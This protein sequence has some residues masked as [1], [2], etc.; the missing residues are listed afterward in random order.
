MFIK[1]ISFLTRGRYCRDRMVVGFTTAFAFDVYNPAHCE[2]YSIQHY[3]IKFASN[4]RQVGGFLR[5]LP[6]VYQLLA[7]GRW[8]SPGTPGTPGTTTSKTVHH[9]ATETLLKVVL[10]TKTQTQ[11]SSLLINAHKHTCRYA[12]VSVHTEGTKITDM[13]IVTAPLT[14]HMMI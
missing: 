13:C 10:N 14:H 11:T 1:S 2:M 8:F 12:V 6:P 7:H 4:L 3:V 9:N 5:V